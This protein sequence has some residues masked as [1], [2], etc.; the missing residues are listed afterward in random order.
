MAIFSLNYFS[1]GIVSNIVTLVDWAS[2]KEF[3]GTVKFKSL[4]YIY[5]G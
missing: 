3:G 4:L 2:A 1:I 5:V